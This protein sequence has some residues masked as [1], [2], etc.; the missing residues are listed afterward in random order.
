MRESASGGVISTIAFEVS[1]AQP[2]GT[3]NVLP[4]RSAAGVSPDITLRATAGAAIGPGAGAGALAAGSGGGVVGTAA[5]L[6]G[7]EQ[8]TRNTTHARLRMGPP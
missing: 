8:A 1:N 4:S 5:G 7:E 3:M 2:T 6:D